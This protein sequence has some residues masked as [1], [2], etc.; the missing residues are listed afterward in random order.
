MRHP[1]DCYITPPCAGIAARRLVETL[2]RRPRYFD[3]FLGPGFLVEHAIPEGCELHGREIDPMWAP[4]LDRRGIHYTIGDSFATDWPDMPI[5]TN[6]PY[7]RNGDAL[8]LIA[9]HCI[10]FKTFALFLAAT[11]YFQHPNRVEPEMIALLKWRP[12]FGYRRDKAGKVGMGTAQAGYA[13]CGMGMAVHP[14]GPL[15]LPVQLMPSLLWV[16][17]PVV[18]KAQ[19]DE[20]RRLAMMAFQVAEGVA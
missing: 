17:R 2:P 16:D 20:H 11:D 13:W 6:V 12:S 14:W 5:V 10:R 8:K 4:E 18:T 1:S 7:S 15:G 3:P 9:A 19:T